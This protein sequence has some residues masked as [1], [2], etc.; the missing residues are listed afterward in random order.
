MGLDEDEQAR[1]LDWASRW[2]V[3]SDWF[4]LE[5]EPTIEALSGLD[6]LVI[7]VEREPL[8]SVAEC[9]RLSRALGSLPIA[10]VGPS[11]PRLESAALRAGA[12]WYLRRDEV[13]GP[14]EGLKRAFAS[15]RAESPRP[16]R[17]LEKLGRAVELDRVARV[18][19]ID[20]ERR[21]PT[22]SKFDLLCYFVDHAGRAVSARELVARG[23]LLP[24]QVARFRSV[25]RE[26]RNYLGPGRNLIRPVTGYGYRLDVDP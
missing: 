25:I 7:D 3:R 23:L 1:V 19:Y 8:L 9:G 12:S 16:P 11:D 10:L 26:L 2:A 21:T 18:L 13:G 24:T 5:I 6:L 22:A 15:L 20:G 4:S 14:W 17:S